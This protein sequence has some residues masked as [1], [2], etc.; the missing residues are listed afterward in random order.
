MLNPTPGLIRID[1]TTGRRREQTTRMV[2]VLA[3]LGQEV[4]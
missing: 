4:R 1:Y 2:V 3:F